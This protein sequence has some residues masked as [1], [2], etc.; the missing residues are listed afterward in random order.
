MFAIGYLVSTQDFNV[1]W[2]YFGWANQTTAMIML[3]AAAAYLAKEAKFHWICTLPAV[4]MTAVT[5]TYLANASIGFGL[6]MNISTPIGIAAS[7]A[8]FAAFSARFLRK[9][10]I[11]TG[12]S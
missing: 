4:F 2:R 12:T 3:W 1:I 5:I 9:A 10:K 7:V 8:A 6:A 11:A